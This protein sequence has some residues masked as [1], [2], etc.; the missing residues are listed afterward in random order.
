MFIKD[1]KIIIWVLVIGIIILGG[2][3]WFLNNRSRSSSLEVVSNMT[4]ATVFKKALVNAAIRGIELDIKRIQKW[5]EAP[6]E[7]LTEGAL[8]RKDL[9]FRLSQLESELK[10]YK[11]MR[12]QDYKPP[13]KRDVVGWVNDACVENTLLHTEN[14]SR[15]G[16]FYHIVGIKGGN[17]SDIKPKVKYKMSIYLV[18]PRF[19]P[20]PDHYIYISSYKQL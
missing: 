6:E 9:E 17:W 11:N 8:R 2:G 18:Y 1:G 14:M 10:K 12:L 19:Y 3:L 16:P 5:L 20:F 13:E 15:S 4:E 7:E